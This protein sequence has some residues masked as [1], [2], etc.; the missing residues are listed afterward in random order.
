LILICREQPLVCHMKVRTC[1]FSL[2]C[3]KVDLYL[4]FSP[5]LTYN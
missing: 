2:S 4:L 5:T 3:T 1:E